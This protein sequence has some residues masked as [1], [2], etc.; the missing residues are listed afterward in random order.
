MKARLQ[1]LFRPPRNEPSPS[2]VNLAL[3]GAAGYFLAL[4]GKAVG[5]ETLN[6]KM[7]PLG[8]LALVI[9]GSFG[10]S[11]LLFRR[12]PADAVVYGAAGSGLAVLVHRVNRT[13]LFQGDR[14]SFL[15]RNDV[16]QVIRKEGAPQR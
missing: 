1:Q 3:C 6:L 9:T 2:G 16:A 11:S 14:L 13:L 15:S 8:K 5:A 10:A 4:L 7:N 12:R